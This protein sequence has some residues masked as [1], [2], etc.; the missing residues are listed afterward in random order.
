[1]E[2]I[3]GK[4]SGFCAGVNYTYNKAKEEIIKG[5]TYC[6]GEI[7]HNN[8]VIKE[9]EDLGMITVNLIEL[10]PDNSR[11]IFRAHGEP[12]EKYNY[13]KEHNLEVVDLTCGRV[14]LIH[15]KVSSEKDNSFIIIIGKK[16]HPEILGTVGFSGKDYF[17]VEGK[18][19]IEEAYN[20]FL[21]SN[22]K[23]IYIVSQTTFSSLLFDE[24]VNHINNKFNNIDIKVDKTICDAT[25]KRQDEVTELSK[26]CNIMLVIGSKQSSNTKELYDIANKNCSEVYFVEDEKSIVDFKINN[27][28]IVGVVAGASAPKY[29]ID[30]IVNVL[31]KKSI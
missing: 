27:D 14:K 18:E 3:V 15:N 7:I 17:V 28:S 4:Y 11:V 26:K 21:K 19:D 25:E 24:L 10:I 22:K 1:M 6:L 12:L 9:L 8:Q 20:K 2:I 13:A 29:L 30:K 16:K 5:K 31:N 23:N